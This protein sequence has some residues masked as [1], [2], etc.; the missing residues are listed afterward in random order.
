MISIYGFMEV[1]Y[2]GT[3]TLVLYYFLSLLA[4]PGVVVMLIVWGIFSWIFWF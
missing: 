1:N 3:V 4:F 2:E